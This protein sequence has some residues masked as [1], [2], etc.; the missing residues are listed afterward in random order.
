[1]YMHGSTLVYIY[2]YIRVYANVICNMQ[3]IMLLYNRT[4]QGDK[5]EGVISCN[6]ITRIIKLYNDALMGKKI[7]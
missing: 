7:L 2:I 3:Y 6:I 5:S 1:M 4:P